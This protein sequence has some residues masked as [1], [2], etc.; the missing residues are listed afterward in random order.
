MIS[1]VY[2]SK[3]WT[4]GWVDMTR[5]Q[6]PSLM[7]SSPNHRTSQT[8]SY[9]QTHFLSQCHDR[10]IRQEGLALKRCVNTIHS[11]PHNNKKPLCWW[12]DLTF[13]AKEWQSLLDATR[14]HGNFLNIF[15]NF[16]KSF[17]ISGF[18]LFVWWCLPGMPAVYTERG[19][20]PLTIRCILT[21]K[22]CFATYPCTGRKRRNLQSKL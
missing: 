12:I 11:K 18:V 5:E 20:G 17:G 8:K 14:T 16:W 21:L 7:S 2:K 3:F 13:R 6:I 4:N 19:G 1:V 22:P 9:L 10:R 15:A